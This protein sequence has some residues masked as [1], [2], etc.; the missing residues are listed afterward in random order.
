[1]PGDAARGAASFRQIDVWCGMRDLLRAI[2]GHAT[3]ELVCSRA[4]VE[5]HDCRSFASVD[6]VVAGER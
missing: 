6:E 4:G 3:S 2:I 5:R 1:L